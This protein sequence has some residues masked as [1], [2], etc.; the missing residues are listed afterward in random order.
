MDGKLISTIKKY[1]RPAKDAVELRPCT[2][3]LLETALA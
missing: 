1:M 2:H 3:P